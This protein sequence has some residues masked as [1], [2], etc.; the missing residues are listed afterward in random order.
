MIERGEL[1]D[2]GEL[3]IPEDRDPYV[4]DA[5]EVEQDFP[6]SFR[7]HGGSW[8]RRAGREARQARGGERK[9]VIFF[10]ARW[11]S[12][13]ERCVGESLGGGAFGR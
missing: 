11:R 12:S 13:W 1:T 8:G 5:W 6:T 4:D 10:R 7:L 3:R 2:G 9:Q